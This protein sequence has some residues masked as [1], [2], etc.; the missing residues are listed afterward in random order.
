[1][2]EYSSTRDAGPPNT[3]PGL[4]PTLAGPAQDATLVEGTDLSK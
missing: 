1:M 2:N 3:S 4:Q